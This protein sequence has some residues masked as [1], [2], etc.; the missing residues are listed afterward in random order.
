[1]LRAVSNMSPTIHDTKRRFLI[2]SSSLQS[3]HGSLAWRDYEDALT[4]F[5]S[6]H[7]AEVVSDHSVRPGAVAQVL[8][9]SR[10]GFGP[11]VLA[12][13]DEPKESVRSGIDE[14]DRVVG[15]IGQVV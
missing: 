12:F 1:M 10:A 7:V 6:P 15:A 9:L 14:V 8:G 2:K 3:T 11:C 4:V 13:P 5:A